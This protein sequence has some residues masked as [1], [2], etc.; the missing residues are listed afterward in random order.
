VIF[1]T[2]GVTEAE[3][4]QHEQYGARRMRDCL[5]EKSLAVAEQA[6]QTLHADVKQFAAGAAAADDLSILA[7]GFRL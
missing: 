5:A 7:I 3:N 6:C 4:Q 1:I 2:D